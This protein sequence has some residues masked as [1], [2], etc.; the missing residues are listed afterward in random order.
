VSGAVRT[1][2]SKAGGPGGALG[3]PVTDTICGLRGGGCGQNFSGGSVYWSSST[4]ARVLSGAVRTRWA[5]ARGIYGSLGYPKTGTTCG[6]RSGGCGQDFAGGSVYW[7]PQTGARVVKG[8][9]RTEWL[10]SGGV[11]GS[12]SYPIAEQRTID[13]G[14]SQRFSGGSLTYR[15]GRWT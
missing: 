8:V 14:W 10:R 1:G 2:W 11:K 13:G 12:Y 5:A 4:G 6:L 3:Y 15:N 7:S 9:I